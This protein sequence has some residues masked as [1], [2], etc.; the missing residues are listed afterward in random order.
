MTMSCR[1]VVAKGQGDDTGILVEEGNTFS[2]LFL[3]IFLEVKKT[4]LKNTKKYIK[5][6]KV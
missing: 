1:G 4:G 6:P 2:R 5:W 3:K